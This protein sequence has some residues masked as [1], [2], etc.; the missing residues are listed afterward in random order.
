MEDGLWTTWDNSG[1]TQRMHS[2]ENFLEAAEYRAFNEHPE[3]LEYE[4]QEFHELTYMDEYLTWSAQEWDSVPNPLVVKY[5][6]NFIGDYFHLIF[7]DSSEAIYDFG[8]GN[9]NF[10][11]VQLFEGEHYIDNEAYLG[12]TFKITWGWKHSVFPC[13]D[14]DYNRTEQYQPSIIKLEIVEE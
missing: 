8:F 3:I 5:D 10:G 14:G 2:Y 7:T 9:N 4:I 12:K 11:G 13:C 6:G 1:D